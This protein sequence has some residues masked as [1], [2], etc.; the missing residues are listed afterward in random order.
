MK[1]RDSK[2]QTAK[3]CVKE[4]DSFRICYRRDCDKSWL[5]RIL[6]IRIVIELESKEIIGIAISKERKICL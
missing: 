3:Y 2:V 4:K 1:L 5:V 6:L